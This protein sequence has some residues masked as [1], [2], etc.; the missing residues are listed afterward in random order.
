MK[1]ENSQ[2]IIISKYLITLKENSQIK[3]KKM[4]LPNGIRK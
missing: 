2:K 1:K 3:L 4:N